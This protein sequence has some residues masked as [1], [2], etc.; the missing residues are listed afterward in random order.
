LNILSIQSH[1]AYGHVGNSAV[2]LPLQRLG[3]NVWP[4]HTAML[5]N[6]TGYSDYGGGA[7][8]AAELA[9]VVD[10][11]DRRGA[12]ERCDAVL[13]GYLGDVAAGDV[14]LDAVA[15]VRTNGDGAMY[16]CDPVMG[17]D[18]A[19]YVDAAI[20]Q[21][22][23]ERAAPAADV[24]TPNLFELAVLV[25]QPPETL[26]GAPLDEIVA[27]AKQL[28]VPKR[29]TSAVLVTSLSHA[30][31]APA[32]VAMAAVTDAGAWLVTT[33]K[34]SLATPP[35]GAGDCC[36]ALFCAGLF[37]EGDAAAALSRTASAI[38]ALL[39]ETARRDKSELALVEA[40]DLMVCP[41]QLF[42][43]QSIR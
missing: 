14:V 12:L 23:R 43:A 1:V 3:H 21:F 31:L 5:S 36:A 27:A 29:R 22:M 16:G 17:D 39:Q 2:V 10:A 7:V 6:H 9:A 26:T 42:S 11:L 33:P 20:P 28:L 24:L 13:S 30:A 18:G 34:L 19:I 38:Y 40:Q 37:D 35:H 32:E 8:P 15:R 4:V 25:D 41:R